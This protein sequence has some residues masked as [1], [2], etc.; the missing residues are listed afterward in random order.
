MYTVVEPVSHGLYQCV[1]QLLEIGT[2]NRPP[3]VIRAVLK[4]LKN[5]GSSN[6]SKTQLQYN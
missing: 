2:D 4:I 3:V 6:K 1:G 5:H